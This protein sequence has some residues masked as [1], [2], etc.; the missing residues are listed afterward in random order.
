MG[1]SKRNFNW[2]K[3]VFQFW[4]KESRFDCGALKKRW[5][6]LDS[7]RPPLEWNGKGFDPEALFSRFRGILTRVQSRLIR[8]ARNVFLCSPG[9]EY[10]RCMYSSTCIPLNYYDVL[11]PWVCEYSHYV[12]TEGGG[13]RANTYFI[14]N[15]SR[16]CFP[17]F[18]WVRKTGPNMPCI[19]AK[20][21][22]L[23][24]F[25]L[26]VLILSF[27]SYLITNFLGASGQVSRYHWP[28]HSG[29]LARENYI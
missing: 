3:V 21:H 9:C 25:L 23:K 4:V 28:S 13:K 12:H 7:E 19:Q 20:I 18:V 6:F 15:S 10:T 24:N 11:A 16:A 17:V 5:G 26:H 14:N 29:M 8:N 27:W 1:R 22:F 2:P